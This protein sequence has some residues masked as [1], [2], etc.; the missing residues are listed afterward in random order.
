[1]S[2][3]EDSDSSCSRGRHRFDVLLSIGTDFKEVDF[4]IGRDIPNKN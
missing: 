2:S 4:F 1:M 3:G